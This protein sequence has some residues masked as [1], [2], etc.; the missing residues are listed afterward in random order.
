MNQY[1][2]M[3]SDIELLDE[4]I[5][6]Y[7]L[8]HESEKNESTFGLPIFEEQASQ[9]LATVA[10]TKGNVN[11]NPNN[12]GELYKIDLSKLENLSLNNTTDFYIDRQSHTIYYANGIEMNGEVYYTVPLDYQLT[13]TNEIGN[14]L[15]CTV[16]FDSAGG[17]EVGT[18]KVRTGEKA[19]M[20]K[21]P[22]KEGH[23]FLGWFYLK[24]TGTED[25]PNYIETEF[26]FD[27][28]LF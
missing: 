13:S 10:T 9:E 27:S 15:Y 25:E 28:L 2:R 1:Y 24:N 6:L 22:K 12:I 16:E 23:E 20:P 14:S 7:Y 8:Q 4:K 18:Q 3:C 11:Y 19:K 5:A 26:D 21:A 17:T